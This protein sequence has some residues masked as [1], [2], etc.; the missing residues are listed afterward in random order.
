ML[1]IVIRIILTKTGNWILSNC[2]L[3]QEI[4]R[5]RINKKELNALFN[6]IWRSRIISIFNWFIIL[7]IKFNEFT[8]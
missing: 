7:T 5:D 6:K 1:E 8:I 4:E 2:S 3:N